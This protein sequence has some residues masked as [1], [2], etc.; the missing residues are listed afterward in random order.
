[1]N[2]TDIIDRLRV[3]GDGDP[4]Q[5]FR[6]LCAHAR[7]CPSCCESWDNDTCSCSC[8]TAVNT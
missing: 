2:V 1:M 4:A 5:G 8:V 3:I 6:L 7:I